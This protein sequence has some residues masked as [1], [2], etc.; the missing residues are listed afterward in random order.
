M[1]ESDSAIAP[2]NAFD[3]GQGACLSRRFVRAATKT[4][5]GISAAAFA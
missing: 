2:K 5:G 4:N 3:V 1:A